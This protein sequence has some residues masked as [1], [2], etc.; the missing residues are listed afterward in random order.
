MKKL[1]LTL[2]FLTVGFASANVTYAF[3][4][5]NCYSDVQILKPHTI[6]FQ[7]SCKNVYCITE[8]EYTDVEL[9]TAAAGLDEAYCNTSGSPKDFEIIRN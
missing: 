6:T 4:I 7:L 1:L 8:K 3:S 5:E 9:Q 2:S